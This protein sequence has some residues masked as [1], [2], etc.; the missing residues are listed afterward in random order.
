MSINK[1]S[2]INAIAKYYLF[3]KKTS[4]AVPFLLT[5]K[6]NF[7]CKYC[8]VW[9]RKKKEMSTENIFKI[10]DELAEQGTERIGYFGGEVLLRNDIKEIIDYTKSKWISVGLGSNG[11]LVKDKIDEIKNIDILHLSFDGPEH[12]HDKHRCLGSYKKLIEAI[13]V[14]KE[15]SIEVWCLC[16]LTK[17]NIRCVDFILNKAKELEF[18]I[19]FHPVMARSC[20]GYSKALLPDSEEFR[21]VINKLIME[22]MHNKL[23]GNSIAGLNYLKSWPKLK[24]MKCWASVF[25]GWID[26]NGDVYP[27]GNILEIIKP[28]NCLEIGFKNAFEKM[29]AFKCDGCFEYANIELNLVFNFNVNS[30]YNARWLLR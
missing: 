5:N 29:Q 13:R 26:T 10:I 6:C 8:G 20:S 23:I 19:F 21:E 1:I 11:Y 15:N 24:P 3:K 22:K 25:R 16:V 28:L 9:N 2:V 14:A 30:I 27:C 4:L 12:V 17:Y 18:K 7:R